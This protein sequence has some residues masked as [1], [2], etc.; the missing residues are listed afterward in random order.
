ML[1]KILILYGIII[2]LLLL[3]VAV[4]YYRGAS[5]YDKNSINWKDNHQSNHLNEK[6]VNTC[7]PVLRFL[8]DVV[9]MR[10]IHF[11]PF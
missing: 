3:L 8:Q 11:I 5:Q 10:Q 6:T 1:K 9:L 2:P 7:I 4:L